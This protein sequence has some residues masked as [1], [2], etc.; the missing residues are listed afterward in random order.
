VPRKKL[1]YL[2]SIRGIAALVVVFHHLILAFLPALKSTFA[3]IQTHHLAF[4]LLGNS[5]LGVFINGHY[6][7]RLFFLLSGFV[8]S[9]SYF[10][11][12]DASVLTSAAVRRYP[13]L[14]IPAL[15]SV[16]FAW[17]IQEFHGFCNTRAAAMMNQDAGSWLNHLYHQHITFFA[18][19]KQG[20]FGA[21]FNFDDSRSLNGSLWTMPVELAGSFFVFSFLALIGPLPRR[22]LVYVILALIF[23][24]NNI[25]M[26]DFLVG[27]ALCDLY[28][29]KEKIGDQRQLSF[30]VAALLMVLGLFLG[31]LSPDWFSFHTHHRAYG[32]DL[33]PTLASLLIVGSAVFCPRIQ[34][35]L[36]HSI[37]S[38]LGRISFPLY[39]FHQA[40]ICSLGCGL[41]LYLKTAAFSHATSALA[42][43]FVTIAAS[44]L[45]A[46]IGYY[47]ADLPSIRAGSK[48]GRFLS[49]P[50]AAQPNPAREI[51]SGNS[52]PVPGQ[53]FPGREIIEPS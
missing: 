32:S 30:L 17:V 28:C 22:F 29:L 1:I 21:F 35:M 20:V 8:L 3:E 23:Y 42:A 40:L 4:R 26:L 6:A 51:V 49:A 34:D 38:F 52:R 39:L 5:P 36:E 31:G 48:L 41:Y 45:M 14:M 2:E 53:P 9:V 18:T 12:R 44:L 33:W 13:R 11:K 15:A 19:I 25:Y 47:A 43:S 16:L 24:R 10:K 7:V 37:F 46:W 27:I 50:E